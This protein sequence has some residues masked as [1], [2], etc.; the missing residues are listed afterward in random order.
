[1]PRKASSRKGNS[2][3]KAAGKPARKRASPQRKASRKAKEAATTAVAYGRDVL[4]RLLSAVAAS[5][6][7]KPA[8]SGKTNPIPARKKKEVAP[9]A[10]RQPR[11]ETDILM[12]QIASSYTPTQTSL[13]APFRASGADRERDQD[14]ARGAGNDRWKDEDRLTNKSG[15][16]RI[17]THGRTYEPGEKRVV[18]SQD[19]E[20]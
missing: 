20:E 3:G 11:R 16:P 4:K 14:Y 8:E 12:D 2:R 6:T 10:A 18:S 9:R 13:K 5:L 19:E 1:M 17:G 15:D 7:R